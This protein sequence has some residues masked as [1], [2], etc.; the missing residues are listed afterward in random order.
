MGEKRNA[1]ASRR[2]VEAYDQV[3][4]VSRYDRDMDLMHP[5]R[6][7]MVAVALEILS[8][9]EPLSTVALELGIGTG[10]FASRFLQRHKKA[11]IIGIDGAAS[12]IELARARLLE[13]GVADRVRFKTSSFEELVPGD[14]E[15]GAVDVVFSSYALHHLAPDAKRSVLDVA[16][17]FLKPGGWF[18]NADLVSHPSPE[19]E[20]IIQRI[21]VAGIVARNTAMTD[22]DPRFIDAVQVR[23]FLDNLE[24]SEGDC[25]MSMEEDLA[26]LSRSGIV[27][28][29]VFWQEY[30]EL[31]MGGQK[32]TAARRG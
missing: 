21:R 8:E 9:R 30:R 13:A 18:L 1:G 3:D 6:H 11:T 27:Y 2:S 14:A 17:S 20:A 10:F 5:N 31:V 4:R 15:I 28:P 24:E 22:P 29:T 26:L 16:L 23:A 32:E 12:M 7:R 25:P 19:V